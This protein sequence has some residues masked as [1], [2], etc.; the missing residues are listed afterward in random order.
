MRRNIARCMWCG[1]QGTCW[2]CTNGERIIAEHWQMPPVSEPLLEEVRARGIVESM[3]MW[4]DI[5]PVNPFGHIFCG[6]DKP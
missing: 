3:V 6:R 1:R 2:N 5:P 4:A